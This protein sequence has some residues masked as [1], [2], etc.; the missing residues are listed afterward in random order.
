MD[1]ICKVL[2]RH[3]PQTAKAALFVQLSS[4]KRAA[5][6]AFLLGFLCLSAGSATANPAAE[7]PLRELSGQ[8]QQQIQNDPVL[9]PRPQPTLKAPEAIAR[10]AP[11][12]EDDGAEKVTVKAFTITGNTLVAS[13]DLQ[14]L[15]RPWVNIPISL[16]ELRRGVAQ[17]AALYRNRGFLAQA[18]LP[19]Q[20]ITEGNVQIQVVEGKVGKVIVEAPEDQPQI[21]AFVRNRVKT[22]LEQTTPPGEPLRLDRF[23][24]AVWVAD[25]LPGVK[26]SASLK[27][28][29][30]M[31]TTDIVLQ[32][33]PTTPI[34]G[35]FSI[36][37]NGS[38]STGP[39]RLNALVQFDSPLGWGESF[40]LSASK[41]RGT[42]FI[43]LAHSIPLGFEGWR[44]STLNLSTSVFDYSVLDAFKPQGATFSPQ[45][46]SRSNGLSVRYPFVRTGQTNFSGELGYESRRSIDRGDTLSV[47]RGTE[48]GVL[49]DTRV[50]SSSL[51][52]SLSHIDGWGGGGSNLLSATFSQGS[53]NLQPDSVRSDDADGANTSGFFRK[54]RLVAN[55]LQVL[56]SKHTAVLSFTGQL[57]NR[58]LDASEKIFLG[59]SSSVRAFPNSEIGGSQGYFATLELRRDWNTE[60]R[61]SY[62]YDYG[63]LWQ[64]KKP[65]RADDPTQ[66]LLTEVAN[67][68]SVDGHGVG[69]SYRHPSGTEFRAQVSRRLR[70]NPLP[71]QEGK[72]KD[73]SLRMNRWW[74][75]LSIPF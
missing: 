28:G 68:Q 40:T 9:T 64:Y 60:W 74:V 25:D 5:F 51:T 14:S 29:E 31:G 43:R 24:W 44:G 30:E 10:P 11:Q 61:T 52:L 4:H 3:I 53:M 7:N 33:T 69:L 75:S 18:V 46:T 22:L 55:R 26:V 41:T 56:D 15:L 70:N 36:D 8:L 45:G 34:W 35:S 66:S 2:W 50:E 47:A 6:R 58:N 65:M 57:A 13:D 48:L 12:P 42:E 62:F 39:L 72:D 54:L 17:V 19:N 16:A 71:T 27:P 20:D 59:G 1:K 38:R 21:G 23:D 37:N 63:K 67:A 73:G 49:R 32:V